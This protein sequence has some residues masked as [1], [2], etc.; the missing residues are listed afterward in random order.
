MLKGQFRRK[1]KDEDTLWLIDTIIDSI[2][3]GLPI[4]NYTSQWFSNFYLE[5]FDHYVKEELKA[6]YYVR[7]MDDICLF[8]NNKKKLHKARKQVEQYLQEVLHVQVKDNWQLFRVDDRGIDFVGYRTFRDH[9]LLRKKTSLRIARKARKI[10]TSE[11]IIY[12]DAAVV[13]SYLGWLKHCNAHN[14]VCRYI[15]PVGKEKKLKKKI[16]EGSRRES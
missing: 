8:S 5:V 2:N 1:I 16:R 10:R 13:M 3:K 7:Y 11:E 12:H 15:F 14:F 4:G 9:Y 6:K